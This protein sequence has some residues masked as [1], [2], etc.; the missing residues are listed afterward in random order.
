[1]KV[2]LTI[3]MFILFS[4][5]VISDSFSGENGKQELGYDNCAA[6]IGTCH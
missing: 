1:M 4:V 6:I 3:L 5:S 2:R